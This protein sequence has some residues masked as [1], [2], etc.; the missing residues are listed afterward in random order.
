M[1]FG[2]FYRTLSPALSLYDGDLI[3]TLA[4]GLRPAHV[5]QVGV[6]AE[7]A[8]AEAILT[9]VRE[10]DGFGILP[11]VRDRPDLS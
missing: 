11:A 4:A 2:G 3:V 8:V 9:A 10:A 1:A 7:R 5:H 6:L